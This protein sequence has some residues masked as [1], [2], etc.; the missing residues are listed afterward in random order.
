[1][2]KRRL[3]EPTSRPIFYSMTKLNERHQALYE[4]IKANPG[5]TAKEIAAFFE[6]HVDPDLQATDNATRCALRRLGEKGFIEFK[7]TKFTRQFP[8]YYVQTP[9]PNV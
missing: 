9:P 4:Y 6:N 8:Q 1:L 7:T 3:D 2:K 5:K